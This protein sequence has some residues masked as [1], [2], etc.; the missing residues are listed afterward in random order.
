MPGAIL[1]KG[2]GR[3]PAVTRAAPVPAT[4]ARAESS[5]G[6]KYRAASDSVCKSQVLGGHGDTGRPRFCSSKDW[7]P[8]SPRFRDSNAEAVALGK[9]GAGR[10][11]CTAQP[12]NKKTPE[13][14]AIPF[15]SAFI[16][17]FSIQGSKKC[18]P[19]KNQSYRRSSAPR[20]PRR[21]PASA[22]GGH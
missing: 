21:A 6:L 15:R 5:A 2:L 12:A 19:H 1:R 17:L 9:I 20:K 10:Y 14:E 13:R 18:N 11:R 4:R 16:E 7:R 22:Q 3:S 8:G